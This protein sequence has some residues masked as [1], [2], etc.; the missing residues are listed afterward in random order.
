MT[1]QFTKGKNPSSLANL[2]KITPDVAKEWQKRSVESRL[3]NKEIREKFKLTAKNFLEVKADLPDLS[4][5]DVLRM[6]MHVALQEDNF[7]DA[8]R[9]AAQIAEYEAPKLQRIDQVNKT[10]VSD[11]SDEDLQ[12]LIAEEGL[13]RE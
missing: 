12:R 11:L 9:Y 7:E 4:A 10:D 1:F 13:R 8:A 5:L 6:A 3:L 2:R